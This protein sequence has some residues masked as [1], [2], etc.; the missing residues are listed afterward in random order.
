M[1]CIYGYKNIISGRWYVGQTTLG[2]KERHRLHLSSS[3]NKK[4]SDYDSL[5][6]KKI[7]EYG[8]ENF[9]LVILEKVH[10]IGELDEREIFWIEEKRSYVKENGYNLTTGGQRR[11]GGNYLDARAAFTTHEEIKSVMEEIKDLNNELTDLAEKHNVSLSLICSINTGV[12]YHKAGEKYPLRPLRRKVSTE[13][14]ES[15]IFL[16]RQGLSN[17]EISDKLELS[18]PNVVYRINYGLAHVQ[19]GLEYPIRTSVPERVSKANEI[20]RLL[21]E[22]GSLTNKEISMIV[23]CDPSTVSNINYGKSY[24]EE[25]LDYPLRK[26]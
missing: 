11:R 20:K 5:F 19:E 25:K 1:K 8:K 22:Q 16:L 9:E 4:A 21:V 26:S 6:H 13:V 18:D 12:K 24:R 23:G 2:I 14:V 3:I 17:L 7:R 10:S 15:V